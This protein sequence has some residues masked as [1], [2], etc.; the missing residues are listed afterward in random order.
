ML[1]AL[2]RSANV[3]GYKIKTYNARDTALSLPTIYQTLPEVETHFV[4]LTVQDMRCSLVCSI[5]STPSGPQNY[6]EPVGGGSLPM[7]NMFVLWR[8]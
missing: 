2:H 5:T 4:C 6:G 1:M 3:P 7:C 8:E